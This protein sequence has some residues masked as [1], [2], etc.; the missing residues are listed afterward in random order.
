[1]L[2]FNTHLMY[3]LDKTFFTIDMT[4]LI[5]FGKLCIFNLI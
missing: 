1:M 2:Y 5:I 3:R 4:L